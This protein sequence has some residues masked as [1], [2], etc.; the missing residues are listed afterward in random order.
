MKIKFNKINN[1]VIPE[2]QSKGQIIHDVQDV[3]DP[4]F[5]VVR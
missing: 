2:L 4:D 3:L 1:N 5:A